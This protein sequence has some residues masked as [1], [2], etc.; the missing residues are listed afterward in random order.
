MPPAA[1]GNTRIAVRVQYADTDAGGVVHHASYLRWFEQ[2]RSQWLRERG[3]T[4][5][6][7]QQQGFVFAVTCAELRYRA[8]LRLDDEAEITARVQERRRST[9]TFAQAAH[10]DGKVAC[11][12]QV[13]LA[14][15]SPESGKPVRIPAAL[16]AANAPE[17][18]AAGAN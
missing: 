14:C 15:L 4:L 1:A 16:L 17:T 5:A 13:R 18:P 11:Q 3:H 8:C 12:A 10:C 2:A 6:Q 9:V 7:L